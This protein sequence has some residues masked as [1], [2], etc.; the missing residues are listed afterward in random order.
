MPD[1]FL[2]RALLSTGWAS[3]VLVSSDEQGRITR[4]EADAELRPG[5]ESLQGIAVPGI[6]NLHS[7]AFQRAMAGLTEARGPE[8]ADSFWTW[9]ER[10]YAFLARL[11]PDDVEAVARQLFVEMLK[12][13]Y[14]S[15]VE[16][17]YLHHD[18]SGR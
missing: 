15:I 5:V 12:A 11:S 6:P 3:R 17:H 16:F 4:L 18:P 9:R 2:P 14:T 7:H 13:G 8:G 1:F 10:M